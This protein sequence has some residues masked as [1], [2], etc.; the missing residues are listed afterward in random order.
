M[1]I[2][3]DLKRRDVTINSIGLQIFSEKDDINKK[4]FNYVDI[5]DKLVDPFGGINDIKNKIWRTTGLAE[6]RFQEDPT[7]MLRAL[8]QSVTMNLSLDTDTKNAII[9]NKNLINITIKEESSSRIADEIV[10]IMKNIN[11]EVN[12]DDILDVFFELRDILYIRHEAK[13]YV[14][15]ELIKNSSTLRV[16]MAYLLT[17]HLD[18]KD[19]VFNSQNWIN[20]FNLSAAPHYSKYD[21]KFINCVSELSNSFAKNMYDVNHLKIH[22]RKT[23][24]KLE[25]IAP[26]YG[27]I[28]FKDFIEYCCGIYKFNFDKE[29]NS[30]LL[31]EIINITVLKIDHVNIN[32]HD[33]MNIYRNVTGNEIKGNKIKEIKSMYFDMIT[34]DQIVND[35]VIL[36]NH[37][38][39]LLI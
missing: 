38:Q 31:N 9:K 16:R 15:G 2:E 32:G 18:D 29:I 36:K 10:Q 33:I 37:Y 39:S 13:K 22:L 20:Y 8:R 3:N 1:S 17:P 19:D 23:L 4:D 6:D 28:Y 14:K 11:N 12:N 24:Q 26:N 30:N 21:V 7:R 35:N 25:M 27:K 5:V 34:R